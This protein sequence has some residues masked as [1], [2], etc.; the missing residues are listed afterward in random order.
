MPA[1]PIAYD[2]YIP[3][4]QA[5]RIRTAAT[6]LLRYNSQHPRVRDAFLVL[7]NDPDVRKLIGTL[8]TLYVDQ[9]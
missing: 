5:D 1:S 8:N 3:G 4:L 9:K 6:K 7:A 2:E